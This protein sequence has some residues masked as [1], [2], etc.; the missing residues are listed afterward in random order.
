MRWF[1]IPQY[2]P[3]VPRLG[4]D[5]VGLLELVVGDKVLDRRR[6]DP[7]LCQH[8]VLSTGEHFTYARGIYP[9]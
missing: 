2:V 3:R 5:L 7:T 1:V 8:S 9:G 4:A 6:I